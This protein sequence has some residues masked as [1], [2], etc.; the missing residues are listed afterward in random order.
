MSF[1]VE[2]FGREGKECDESS[3]LPGESHLG[4]ELKE[5]KD[6]PRLDFELP[7]FALVFAFLVFARLGREGKECEELSRLAEVSH[8]GAELEEDASQ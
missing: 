5:C 8:L 3:R 4:T 1:V 6:S 7:A 2:R